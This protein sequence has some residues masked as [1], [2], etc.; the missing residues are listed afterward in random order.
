MKEYRV[1]ARFNGTVY[2]SR[3]YKRKTVYTKEDALK[4]HGEALD[5]YANTKCYSKYL[6]DVLIEARECTD[7]EIVQGENYD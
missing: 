5:Y 1:V 6:K 7:W 4:L 2:N 3:A